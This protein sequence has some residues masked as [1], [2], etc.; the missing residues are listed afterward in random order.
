MAHLLDWYRKCTTTTLQRGS[1]PWV[2]CTTDTEKKTRR[3]PTSSVV[4]DRLLDDGPIRNNG[5]LVWE[6]GKE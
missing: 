5:H 2:P 1:K 6:L 3:S 4:D